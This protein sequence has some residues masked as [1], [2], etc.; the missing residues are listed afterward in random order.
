MSRTQA[1]FLLLPAVLMLSC[2]SPSDQPPS[3]AVSVAITP[4]TVTIQVGQ[5]VDL[6]GAT[7]G[8]TQA[9][10]IDWWEQDQHDASKDGTGSEDC[11]NITPQNSNLIASCSFGY[12]TGSAVT[13]ATS[14]T[15]TYHA[16]MTPGVYHVTFHATQMSLQQWGPSVTARAIATIMVTQ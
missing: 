12:L 10:L 2:G 8:F 7:A 11:D 1:V 4:A 9:P 15:A 16:P 14:G 5:T 13:Q 6:H 3:S